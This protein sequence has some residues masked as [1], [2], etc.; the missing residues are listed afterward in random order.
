M[1]SHPANVADEIQ[2]RQRASLLAVGTANPAN[3]IRQDDYTDWYFRV[4]K[5]DHLQDLKAKMRRLCDR[6]S[7]RRRYFHHSERTILDHHVLLSGQQQLPSLDARQDILV[8]AVP[9]LAAA[10]AEDTI[11]EWG[12]PASDITHLVVSTNSGPTC[13]TPTYAWPPY[14]A[15]GPRAVPVKSVA[16]CETKYD[17]PIYANTEGR[18]GKTAAGDLLNAVKPPPA[19]RR[20][21]AG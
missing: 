14:S 5:S 17:G 18:V 15:S 16:L 10:A 20:S 11:A 19:S 6:S 21:T 1:A 3:C 13:P 7:I 4:T 12:H 8:T 9:E 2:Q